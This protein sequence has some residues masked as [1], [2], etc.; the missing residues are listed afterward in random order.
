MA[1]ATYFGRGIFSQRMFGRNSSDTVRVIVS[2]VPL[3]C[4]KN[5]YTSLYGDSRSGVHTVKN[6][7]F[8]ELLNWGSRGRV[9]V[10]PKGSKILLHWMVITSPIK[11][12]SSIYTSFHKPHHN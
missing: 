12:S 8:T 6:E 2:G 11:A 10:T 4:E 1:S 9:M 7:E 5:Y 3:L